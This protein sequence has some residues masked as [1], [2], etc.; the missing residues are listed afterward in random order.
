MSRHLDN[1]DR[2]CNKLQRR[3]GVQDPLCLQAKEALEAS[4]AQ[5]SPGPGQ[6]DWSVPYRVLVQDRQGDFMQLV[7]RPATRP[8]S[9]S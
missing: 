3:Y 1:L 6:P 2:L 4:K 9:D 8:H 7:Q 5:R